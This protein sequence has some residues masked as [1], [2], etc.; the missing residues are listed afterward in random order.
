MRQYSAAVMSNEEIMPHI[1]LIEMDVPGMHGD[2]LPGQFVMV[3]CGPGRML[4]RPISIHGR[5]SQGSIVLLVNIVGK[6]T[7]WLAERGKGETLHIIGPS[8]NGFTVHSQ[9]KNLLMI[10][11][12]MGIA[13]MLFLA[14]C[15]AAVR[16]VT[17]LTGAL[18][19]SLLYPQDRITHGIHT[20][21]MTDD[22]SAGDKGMI[23]DV[24]SQHLN[25]AD[26]IFA[27][28]PLP[29][30]RSIK[31]ITDA[32]GK[33]A[34][35]QVSLEV[36]MGCGVGTCYGCSIKTAKGMKK[37]CKDGPV[38]NLSEILLDEIRV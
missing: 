1:R 19:R 27:C 30:Y 7:E 18:N 20:V 13:P 4:P 3:N 35:V 34:A 8:G 6:G 21:F 10:A 29:M 25:N 23:T 38:F 11:G 26:Q 2:I 36:R 15:E 32:A 37:V 22:G 12:G 16:H 17:L 24:L 14:G 5:T 9:S 31:K 28:G 33:T